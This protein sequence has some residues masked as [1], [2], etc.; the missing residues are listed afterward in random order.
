VGFPPY[1]PTGFAATVFGDRYAIRD[2]E[3]FAQACQRV[4]G[5]IAWAEEGA[6]RG[7]YAG[8]FYDLLV[9]NRFSP[10]GRM[11]RGSGRPRGQLGNCFTW[12]DALDSREGWGD[13]L[14]AVTIISGTGGGVGL[15][16]SKVRPRGS[17]IRGTGGVATGSVSL[18][19]CLNAVCN[20]LREGGGRRSA[21]MFCLGY[22]HPDLPEFLE[23]KLNRGQL[24]NA[25]ISVLIDDEF[26]KLV[27]EDGEIVLRWQGEERGRVRAK[28]VWG[29]I[30]RNAWAT[31]DPGLL[32]LGLAQRMNTLHY[33][34][35]LV[36]PNPCSEIWM[37]AYECCCLGAVV[38]PTHVRNGGIDWDALEETVTL[39][40]RFLDDVLD[41]NHYPLP[42][43]EETCRRYRR[44][45]LG[46]MGLHDLLLELGVRYDSDQALK[47]TDEV[48]DVIK[49][50][51]YES[52]IRLAIEKGPFSAIYREK[53][54]RSGFATEC[55]PPD[56]R[57]K[58][59]EHGIRNCAILTV[60]PTGTTSIVA[61]CS[62]G[63][64]PIFAPV[65][66]QRFHQHGHAHGGQ[67]LESSEIVVHPLLARFL[68]EGRSIEHFQGAHEIDP[69]QHCAVQEACQKHI[70]NA[71]S[72]TIN[73]PNDYPVEQLSQ[74]MRRFISRLKGLTIYRHGSRGESPMTPLPIAE[75]AKHLDNLTIGA[76]V[77][78]CPA[79]A[80]EL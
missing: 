74:T 45:G 20:E 25:N 36:C 2:G 37:S 16:F 64:E 55:L 5:F 39:A 24:E 68:R 22:D 1:T 40:V 35:R 34:V 71:I 73:L 23:A 54:A 50:A 63:I 56:L 6:E 31:G 15:N 52:S 19:R 62:S 69:E 12:T 33:R 66:R 53:H 57:R 58:I 17:P 41:R 21:L 75:A 77:G 18:M 14:R 7:D 42:I 9:T 43:I 26:L 76:A 10:G 70:D 79:G 48:M 65:Y 28:E 47:I 11:W 3:T 4:A 30:V 32:N 49:R 80:C 59:E 72:K 8:R 78:D 13:A 60:A 61:A 67:S 51:A 29:K 27:D 44:I 38:L 46:V